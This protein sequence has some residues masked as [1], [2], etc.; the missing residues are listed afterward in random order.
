M[1]F[2]KRNYLFFVSFIVDKKFLWIEEIEN[3]T[4]FEQ[5]FEIFNNRV[6]ER[7]ITRFLHCVLGEME[8]G[9]QGH[10]SKAIL[11]ESFYKF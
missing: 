7:F 3:V 11:Y 9:I 4:L 2:F 5:K 6:N 8:F 1:L 10:F